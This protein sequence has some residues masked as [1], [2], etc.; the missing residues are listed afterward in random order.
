MALKNVAECAALRLSARERLTTFAYIGT[1]LGSFVSTTSP[2]TRLVT[3][4]GRFHVDDVFAG[5]VLRKLFP[6]AALVRTREMRVLQEANDDPAA[7][8]FDVGARYQPSLHCYDHHQFVLRLRRQD[9]H[10]EHPDAR[11]P[12][13]VPYAAF[14]LVWK[15]FGADYIAVLCG[16]AG[17]GPDAVREVQRDVDLNLVEGIDACDCGSL[18]ATSRLRLR[19]ERRVLV[20]GLADLVAD[21]NPDGDVSDEEGAFVH[22]M[23]FAD[24]V[25]EGRVKAAQRAWVARQAVQAA[26]T[27][28]PVLVL[29]QGVAWTGHTAPHH[30]LV[31]FPE[32]GRDGWLVQSVASAED[33]FEPLLPLPSAWAGLRGDALRAVCG[34]P[35]AEFCHGGRF[36]AGAR[37]LEGAQ[38]LAR[39]ALAEGE[40]LG[41]YPP[42]LTATGSR[43]RVTVVS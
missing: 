26:T 18:E 19:P 41:M 42:I 36:I 39:L 31:I 24:T 4:W 7:V 23:D 8:V 30:C 37:S 40:A 15:H 10:T 33:A 1:A 14:G 22:A 43:R 9:T 35:D 27:S 34:V 13:G 2:I 11:R 28:S 38:H 20:L 16:D 12:D 17:L 25:L 6:T 32:R 29:H 5:S 3:H 21:M